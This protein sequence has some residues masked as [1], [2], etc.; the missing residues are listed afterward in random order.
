MERLITLYKDLAD[1]T[2][3]HC[4][5]TCRRMGSCCE[6]AYCFIAIET[7][8]E[9]YGLE[10]TPTGN[11]VP[12]LDDNGCC[13]APPHVRQMCASHSC[14]I[15]SVG[16]FK[17]EPELTEKYFVIRDEIETIELQRYEEK[18]QHADQKEA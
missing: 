16:F 15:S 2:L 9:E 14:D 17:G 11:K 12:L 13:I 8:K 6:P 4:K 1:L 3:E 5:R 10:L 7:A 18:E